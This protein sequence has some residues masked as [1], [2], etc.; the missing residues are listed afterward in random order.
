MTKA[1]TWLSL[2]VVTTLPAALSFLLCIQIQI[3]KI[4]QIPRG[5]LQDCKR[6]TNDW[7]HLAGT[8]QVVLPLSSHT[9]WSTR[10]Q[11]SQT[12]QG[13]CTRVLLISLRVRTNLNCFLYD[14][15]CFITTGIQNLCNIYVLL[16]DLQRWNYLEWT[17]MTNQVHN[18]T[19]KAFPLQL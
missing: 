15:Y 2:F 16:W 11:W 14:F 3:C 1:A 7:D 18:Q 13:V 10:V 8:A 4:H 17:G 6:Y 12:Y 5:Q 9:E 19:F